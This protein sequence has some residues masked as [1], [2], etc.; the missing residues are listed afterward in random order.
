MSNYEAEEPGFD[1]IIATARSRFKMAVQAEQ[2]QRVA[3]M[4]DFRFCDPDKQWSEQDRNSRE[5]DG[6]PCLTVDRIT[7]FCKQIVNAMR[8]N[9]QS[10][11]VVPL[12]DGA[13]QDAAEVRQGII[14]DVELQSSA[15]QAYITAYESAV[16][17]GIGYWRVATEYADDQT[18]DQDIRIKRIAN[19]MSVYVDPTYK[20]ADGSDIE[21]A[22][23]V[24][25]LTKDEFLRMYPK[26]ELATAGDFFL[27]SL[28]DDAPNWCL[29]NGRL[30]RVAD[31][32]YKSYET[33]TLH[34]LDDGRVVREVPPG[35]R[36][37][38][39]RKTKTSKVMACKINGVEVLAKT[40]FPSKYIPVIPVFGDEL[41][42]DGE[43]IYAGVIRTAKD[44]Q[45]LFNFM[46]TAQAEAIDMSAKAP[47][48][49]PE[50]FDMGHEEEWRLANRKFMSSLKYAVQDFNGQ[51]L[52]PPTRNVMEP[53][54]QAITMS[55]R[56]AEE[57]L[58]ATTGMYD[59]AL[60][61]YRSGDQSG[62][63]IQSLQNQG[64]TSNYHFADNFARAL[65][66]TGKIILDMMPRVLDTPRIMR[67]VKEDDSSDM[68]PINGAEMLEGPEATPKKSYDMSDGRYDVTVQT[69]PAF[70][71]KRQENLQSMLQIGQSY[72]PFF[73]IG[74]DIV[75]SQMDFP[76][77]RELAERFKKMLPPQL[78][79]QKQGPEV[80]PQQMQMLMMQHEQLTQT[81]NALQD[82]LDDKDKEIAAKVH[83]AEIQANTELVKTQMQ[84]GSKEALTQLQEELAYLKHRLEAFDAQQQSEMAHEA[85]ETPQ[86]E[87]QEDEGGM[88]V[89]PEPAAPQ[90][91]PQEQSFTPGSPGLPGEGLP[92]P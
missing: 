58:K 61:N 35:A 50:G 29:G 76:G 56:G 32:Y 43:R 22:F 37:V 68:V 46:K 15:G 70:G 1:P 85:A 79:D 36:V 25:D 41:N 69:G 63:A 82:Q 33:V 24:E 60:G 83:I 30:I 92:Q 84:L 27:R 62:I 5:A 53:A 2:E 39:S 86:M 88:G 77:A 78:Q 42:V 72:P 51:L 57:D 59:P 64:A 75:V 8:Q 34:L 14:R 81:V 87:A 16:R 80:D 40:E 71:T 12:S 48:I 18:F 26:S 3:S 52:P 23:V 19:W 20:E 54:I 31:Y 7:P 74:A 4:D 90:M 9:P 47:W 55:M 38:K 10:I 6:R 11:H 44:P 73:Q 21:W 17:S 67:I 13:A 66:L 28:G 65:K 89:P 91:A 49:G 45:R